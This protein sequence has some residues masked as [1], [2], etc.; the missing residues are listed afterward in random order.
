MILF[1]QTNT[2]E[3]S[4]MDTSIKD[5]LVHIE[6]G[7]DFS[8]MSETRGLFLENKIL[9]NGADLFDGRDYDISGCVFYRCI[10][11]THFEG[12]NCLALECEKVSTSLDLNLFGLD[13]TGVKLQRAN[14]QGA[15]LGRTI[16]SQ[17]N[18]QSV[19]L[20][21]ADLSSADLIEADLRNANLSTA[22]LQVANLRRA[23]LDNANLQGANLQNANLTAARLHNADFR[24]ANLEGA[25]FSGADLSGANFTGA[26]LTDVKIR[27]A[28]YDSYTQGLT[29][30]LLPK[31]AMTTNL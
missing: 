17:A 25:F 15:K 7:V 12:L 18:L 29:S 27:G 31:M 28:V 30:D 5:A 4:I 26:N 8:T 1:S 21:S 9:F 22:D 20:K 6:L 24:N 10:F 16:L 19:N 14:L 23:N 11:A 2:T 13:F 3:G